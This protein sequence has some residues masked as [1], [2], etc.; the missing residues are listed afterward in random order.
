M[1]LNMLVPVC[2]SRR[3]HVQRVLPLHPQHVELVA[4]EVDDHDVFPVIST[5]S[6][7][8]PISQI[9]SFPTQQVTPNSKTPTDQANKF[10]IS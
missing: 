8:C 9:L 3:V 6:H 1:N 10:Q 4:I 2:S 5:L 7:A